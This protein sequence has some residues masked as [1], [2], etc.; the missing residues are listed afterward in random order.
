MEALPAPERF[1]LIGCGTLTESDI[2]SFNI[3][4]SFIVAVAVKL[5]DF[6]LS[7]ESP[8][9]GKDCEGAEQLVPEN[10]MFPLE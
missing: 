7:S 6:E 10:V 2:A 4:V 9:A 5:K 8:I 3:F 1:A